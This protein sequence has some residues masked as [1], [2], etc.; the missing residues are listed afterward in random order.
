MQPKTARPNV[1]TLGYYHPSLRD[2]SPCILHRI[3][4]NVVVADLQHSL[5]ILLVNPSN[6]LLSRPPAGLD[7]RQNL[8]KFIIRCVVSLRPDAQAWACGFGRNRSL[9]KK[10]CYE[11]TSMRPCGS[12]IVRNHCSDCARRWRLLRVWRLWIL[13]QAVLWSGILPARGP[14]LLCTGCPRL[15]RSASVLCPTGL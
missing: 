9:R 14:S 5:K 8:N 13:F 6:P 15:L 2:G 10:H 1:E 4:R 11:K 12:G 7:S 3:L